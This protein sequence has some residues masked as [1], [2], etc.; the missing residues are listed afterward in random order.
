MLAFVSGRVR[1]FFGFWR[2]C[3]SR[4]DVNFKTYS[5]LKIIKNLEEKSVVKTS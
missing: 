2:G 1:C 4:L 5:Q 3:E